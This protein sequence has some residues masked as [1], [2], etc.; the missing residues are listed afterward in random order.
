MGAL[1]PA[2]TL[3]RGSDQGVVEIKPS[4]VRRTIWNIAVGA[5]LGTAIALGSIALVYVAHLIVV[6]LR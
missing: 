3:L 4:S 1:G 6:H 2:G 5:F